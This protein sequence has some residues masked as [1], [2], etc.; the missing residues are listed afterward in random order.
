MKKNFLSVMAAMV[1]GAVGISTHASAGIGDWKNYTNMK[2]VVALVNAHDAVWAGTSGGLLR[3]TVQDSAFKKFTNSEGLTDNGISALGLGPNGTVWIGEASGAIDVLSPSSNS[4]QYIR[5]ISLSTKPQKSVNAFFSQ[6]DSMYIA[7]AFGVSLFSI[8]KFE[9]KDT[10]SN[11]GSFASPNVSSLVVYG[12][13][14]YVATSSGLAIS[15]PNAVNLAAPESWDSFTNPGNANAMASFRGNVYAASNGGLF[16]FQNGAWSSISGITQ[17]VKAL[18]STDSLLYVVGTNTVVTLSPS[19][20]ISTYGGTAPGTIA[21]AA[22]DSSNRFFAG[23]RDGGVALLNTGLNQ[24]KQFI[25][26][27]P[28]SN[29]FSSIAVDEKGVV[30]AASASAKGKGFY[31]YD[32]TKWNNYNIAALPGLKDDN[33]FN[34][35]IGPNNSKWFGSWGGGLALINSAGT[36]VRVFDD[37]FPGFVGAIDAWYVVAGKA[38]SDRFGNVWVSL[39]NSLNG[40]VLWKMKPDSTWVSYRSALSNSYNLILGL[41]TDRNGTIWCLSNLPNALVRGEFMYFNESAPV[42]GLE[43]DHWGQLTATDGVTSTSITC[44]T[45]DNDGA[46]W[47]GTDV[48][49]TV[50]GEPLYPKSRITKVFLGAVR[51][52]FINAIAVDALNNKWIGSRQ[53]V[54]VVSPDGTSLIAQHDVANTNGKLVD[55]NVLSIAFDEK[56]GI[57]YFGTGKGLSSLEIPAI[58]TVEKLASLEVAP[59]PFVLPDNSSVS[60]RGLAE[61]T[62]IKILSV[63]GALI[64]QFAAQGGGRAFWDGTDAIGKTVG[65]GVYLVVAYAE[66]GSQ[67][68][69]AKVAVVRR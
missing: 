7:T 11:F 31:S 29:F 15:K 19:N 51:D 14:I 38:A 33:Y 12:G 17:S 28:A 4:W 53:G 66:N 32:G 26:D 48:G 50:I 36:L 16:V 55:N 64:R 24:W 18:V 41:A 43:S 47:I 39:Y 20:M 35:S 3:F 25:P 21:C 2:D 56:R 37:K 68:S 69:T 46:L 13:R 1:A 63:T 45:E 60:I 10:Y 58:A 62:T 65:S 54:I 22:L 34:V 8:S 67:V 27:G 5:D 30:W 40:N 52:L 42:S 9:F 49:I 57:A 61:N 44:V 23:L 6:G 59:N